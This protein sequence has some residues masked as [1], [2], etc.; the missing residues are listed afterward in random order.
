MS[1]VRCPGVR[2]LIEDYWNQELSGTL[3]ISIDTNEELLS[4][5]CHY[6]HCGLPL[7][8]NELLSKFQFWKI[9]KELQLESLGN[10][11]LSHLE[12]ILSTENLSDII[13]FSEEINSLELLNACELFQKKRKSYQ[14]TS[15]SSLSK[16]SLE[17]TQQSP[18]L[19]QP[20]QP[21]QQQSLQRPLPKRSDSVNST[22]SS[23]A[24]HEKVAESLSDVD[25]LLSSTIDPPAPSSYRKQPPSSSSST[26]RKGMTTERTSTELT[27]NDLVN[28]NLS[29]SESIYDFGGDES[30]NNNNIIMNNRHKEVDYSLD[31]S[32]IMTRST[33]DR[34][35]DVDSTL[36]NYAS[37]ISSI[38]LS[39]QQQQQHQKNSTNGTKSSTLK[40]KSG[41]IYTLMLKEMGTKNESNGAT[42]TDKRSQTRASMSSST[43]RRSSKTKGSLSKSMDHSFS[44]D[45]M[46]NTSSSNA[47]DTSGEISEYKPEMSLLPP[48]KKNPHAKK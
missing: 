47:L 22:T 43:T 28:L 18:Q 24:L 2:S 26:V 21:Q 36:E 42:A 5:L 15:S 31:L 27:L 13:R 23:N 14:Q 29:T 48:P 7:F 38:P 46:L 30:M 25:K 39:K 6:L 32:N 9:A 41:G 44:K 34:L 37:T 1:L 17:Q 3:E 40:P 19:Q 12:S 35:L 10:L 4:C 8:P 20:Q 33:M 11:I 16:T 45:D